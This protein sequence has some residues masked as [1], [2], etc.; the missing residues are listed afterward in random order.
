[1][2]WVETDSLSFSA[3]HESED[4]DAA[5]ATLERLEEFRSRLDRLF[6]VTPGDVSVV[7]HAHPAA[8]ALAHPWLPLAR[9][10]TA[11]AG[12]RYMAG[13]FSSGEIHVLSPAALA[14]RASRVEGSREALLLAPL[15]EYAHL[16]VAANNRLFPPPFTTR[17]FSRYIRWAWLCEGAAVHFSGQLRHLRAAIARRLREGGRPA[18]PPDARDAMLLGG[19]VLGLLE[20][21]A[22][23]NACVDL[24]TRLDP[25]G[26]VAAIER[27]FERP[28]PDVER[29]WRDYLDGAL[30]AS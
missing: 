7:M 9:V 30:A 27:A 13:W 25:A 18:F 2:A 12:R 19:T 5:E 6:E 16:V 14:A 11:P 22:G 3:R 23:S 24:V 17:S 28:L 29:E 15:H 1:V 4:A 10:M 8:L 20:R 26:A 21:S